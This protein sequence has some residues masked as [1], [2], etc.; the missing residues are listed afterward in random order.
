MTR[1]VLTTPES[2]PGSRARFT[3][4]TDLCFAVHQ[5]PEDA[6]KNFVT[7][8]AV[9]RGDGLSSPPPRTTSRP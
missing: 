9:N 5:S 8:A 3:S 7:D 2:R 4:S 6:P 1:T